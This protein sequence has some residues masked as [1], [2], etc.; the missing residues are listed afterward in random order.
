[1]DSKPPMTRAPTDAEPPRGKKFN[2]PW[3]N[4]S[5][6]LFCSNEGVSPYPRIPVYSHLYLLSYSLLVQ[7]CFLSHA[8]CFKLGLAAYTGP[9]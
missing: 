2:P 6:P 1:M 3:K 4:S 8:A 5:L 7:I 9:H